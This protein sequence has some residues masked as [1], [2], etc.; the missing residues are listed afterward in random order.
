M[1]VRM[2]IV[3]ANDRL[4]YTHKPGM[5]YLMLELEMLTL[6]CHLYM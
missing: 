4:Q 5:V 6:Y 3:I 2:T 1:E